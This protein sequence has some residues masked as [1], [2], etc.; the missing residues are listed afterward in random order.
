M[1]PRVSVVVPTFNR[2]KDIKLLADLVRREFS[3]SGVAYL[4]AD[5]SDDPD[6]R[7]AN[8]AHC[9]ASSIRY[10]PFEPGYDLFLRVRECLDHVES[11]LAV[12][13]GDDDLLWRDGLLDAAAFLSA[14]P[15]Y[16]SAHGRYF[17]YATGNIHQV[18]RAY[19]GPSIE[20]DDPLARMWRCVGYYAAPLVY[21]LHRTAQLKLLFEAVIRLN[22]GVRDP[23]GFEIPFAAISALLGKQKRLDSV[24][25]LR[26]YAPGHRAIYSVEF[27]APPFS[28]RLATIRDLLLEFVP[29]S[30]ARGPLVVDA[31]LAGFMGT[32]LIDERKSVRN[33]AEGVRARIAGE[34]PGG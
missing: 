15:D 21:A 4:L 34:A 20:L 29:A 24:Y 23:M 16:A 8:E 25:S 3:G 1:P 7:R 28:A 22:P 10:V 6:A 26:R 31:A 9:R 30:D 19:Q 11:E 27:F 18:G 17:S 2:P 12:M 5:G 32:Q 13:L 33:W 14:H